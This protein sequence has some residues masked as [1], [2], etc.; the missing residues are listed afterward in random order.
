MILFKQVF[1]NLIKANFILLLTPR[2][3]NSIKSNFF[4]LHI[5]IKIF[6]S[7][8]FFLIFLIPNSFAEEESAWSGWD[9]ESEINV[10]IVGS[11]VINLDTSNRLIRAYVDIVNFDPSD[12]YYTMKIIQPITGKIISEKEIVV[13]EKSNG[14]AGTDVAY[15]INEDE[16]TENN[17]AILGDYSIEVSSARGNSIGGAIFSII[18]PSESGVTSISE[19]F[20]LEEITENIDDLNQTETIDEQIEEELEIDNIQKI[21][22]WVKTIFILYADG[23]I[24]ENELIAALSFLIEQGI[25]IITQ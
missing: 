10:S 23:S 13:R 24:T 9:E 16:I 25:I 14:A 6:L 7:S 4:I 19:E 20:D 18:F 15:L 5:D 2:F 21:P 3:N 11:S 17:T 22:D 12:G 1:N 8:A